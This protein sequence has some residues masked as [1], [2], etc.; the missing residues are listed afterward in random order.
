MLYVTKHGLTANAGVAYKE[1]IESVLQMEIT[2]DE[3]KK[4]GDDWAAFCK[5]P[6]R[7]KGT[8]VAE[9]VKLYISN[10]RLLQK[11]LAN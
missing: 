11:Q 3:A 5:E 4:L 1:R 8:V 2:L 7:Y 9:M 6:D 10:N